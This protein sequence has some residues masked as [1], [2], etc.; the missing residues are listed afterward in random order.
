MRA[1]EK[2]KEASEKNE[3]AVLVASD[4]AARGLDI[5]NIDHVVHYHLPRSAD[6]YIHRSGRTAR[7]GKEGVSVMFC[8]P[9][10]A[11]GPLRK[12][13]RLVAANSEKQASRLNMHND[14]KL[15]PIE[16]DLVSQ[17]KPR[18]DISSKLADGNISA[19]ATRKEKSWVEQAAEDLGV[20]DLSDIDNF[21]DDII[22][23]QRKR[24][25]AKMLS[26]D[27]TKVLRYELKSLLAAPIKK[28]ARRSYIT[29]GLQNLA[30]QMVTGAHHEDVLGHE[31]VN[32][33]KDLKGSK[34]SKIK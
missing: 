3:V 8:S 24:K 15:L 34:M 11:S 26:K 31:K 13:R 27:Q 19:T 7:A 18:V 2:F 32:A 6:V 33:L 12:L 21:E 22:K 17:I 5:P 9:Q 1:L 10:E 29:S 25:E 14:V 16:M 4:V 28:N 20:D 30:H 23:K